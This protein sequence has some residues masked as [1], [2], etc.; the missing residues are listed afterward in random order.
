[1]NISI[2]VKSKTAIRFKPSVTSTLLMGQLQPPAIIPVVEYKAFYQRCFWRLW[3]HQ[4]DVVF[5]GEAPSIQ[6]LL[7]R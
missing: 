7:R 1:M 2:G 5:R 6:R 4:H 3:N